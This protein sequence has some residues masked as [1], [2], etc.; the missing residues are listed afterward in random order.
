MPTKDLICLAFDFYLSEF[1]MGFSV[2][3]DH[4]IPKRSLEKHGDCAVETLLQQASSW[5]KLKDFF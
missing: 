2:S 1:Q 3:V 5:N 4:V